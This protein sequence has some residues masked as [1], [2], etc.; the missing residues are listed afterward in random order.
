MTAENGMYKSVGGS[1]PPPL[2]DIF[3][4]PS[5]VV[6]TL[7]ARYWPTGVA[8]GVMPDRYEQLKNLSNGALPLAP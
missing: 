1:V 2:T 6:R 5:S 8:V 3:S 7:L 4:C